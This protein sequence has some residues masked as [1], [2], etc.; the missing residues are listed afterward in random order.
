[1]RIRQP[2]SRYGSRS[3]RSCPARTAAASQMLAGLPEDER[4]SVWAEVE[5]GLEQF[6]GPDGFAGP[7]E[8]LV[9]AATKG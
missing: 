1:M 3:V 8:L 5:A 7:C 9:V 6:E 2:D 4:P